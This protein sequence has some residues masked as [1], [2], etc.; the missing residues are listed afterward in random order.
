MLQSANTTI[1][2]CAF[3]A[4]MGSFSSAQPP[5][6]PDTVVAGPLS[7]GSAEET[8]RSRLVTPPSHHP[9]GQLPTPPCTEEPDSK[10]PSTTQFVYDFCRYLYEGGAAPP[11]EL[12]AKE[13]ITFQLPVEEYVAFTD[14]L[15][16]RPS[17][18]AFVADKV[19]YDYGSRAK[20]I[21]FRMACSE[22][23]DLVIQLQFSWRDHLISPCLQC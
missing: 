3:A 16:R 20:Q 2:F 12:L 11:K 6:D 13:W 14:K 15:K 23:N 10:D 9:T 21:A 4:I 1:S 18:D 22:H 5:N 8:N 19:K 7:L 17:L